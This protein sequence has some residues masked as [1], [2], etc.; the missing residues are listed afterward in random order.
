MHRN[1]FV[2]SLAIEN[3]FHPI[4]SPGFYDSRR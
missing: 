3:F 1:D 2:V 4:P